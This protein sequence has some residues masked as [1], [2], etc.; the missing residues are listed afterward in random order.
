MC[1]SLHSITDK[2]LCT[3]VITDGDSDVF[4]KP[5][6]TGMRNLNFINDM[7]IPQNFS[8]IFT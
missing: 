1:F 2:K 5:N 7:K 8:V 6:V 3:V 4:Y